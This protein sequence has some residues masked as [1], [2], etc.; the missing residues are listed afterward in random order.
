MNI[1]ITGACGLLGAHLM[2]ALSRRHNVVGVDRHSW[3]GDQPAKVLVGD[4]A[5]PGF[6]SE[7]VAAVKPDIL[8]HCA[9]LV[10]VDA[11]EQDPTL[12][13]AC[14]TDITRNLARA[15][16]PHCLVVYITTD[17]IFRGDTPFATEA[18]LPCP[19]TVYGRSKLH[20]E[21]EVELATENHLI[22]RTNFYGWSSGRKQTAAEWLYHALDTGKSIMLFDDFFFTPI[23]VVDLV[24]RLGPL[25]EG[26]H[27]GTFHLC[28]KDRVSKGEFGTQM[29][30]AA[31]LSLKNVQWGSIESAQLAAP[32]PKDMSLSSERFRGL[33]GV[34]VP[35]C[36]AG[37]RRFLADRRRP[38]SARFDGLENLRHVE[39]PMLKVTGG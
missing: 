33:T 34:D 22:I 1:L 24:G 32:R 12:A 18:Q 28:G 17:G 19:R 3:W 7:T 13:Y 11:C 8:I 38:L 27:R 30:K 10:S 39:V 29:A 20:G 4:L 21:W 15:A 35:G 37:L 36:M 2:A 31:G 9:A 14:N 23:Y 5:A 25:L 6:V 26:E 16:P